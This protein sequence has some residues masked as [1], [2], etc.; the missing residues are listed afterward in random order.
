[1]KTITIKEVQNGFKVQIDLYLNLKA[2][3]Y[4]IAISILILVKTY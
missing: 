3:D 1:M 2:K 4:S